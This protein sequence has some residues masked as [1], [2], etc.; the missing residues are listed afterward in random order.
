MREREVEEQQV[1]VE[2][3]LLERVDRRRHLV[4]VAVADHAGLRRA[5]RP[6]R[7]D[8]GE[9]VVLADPAL[10]V[11]ERVG[12]L[13]AVRAASFLELVERFQREHVRQ[14]GDEVAAR[15][16]VED[17]NR[18]DQ[19][20]HVGRIAGRARGIDRRG[21]CADPGECEVRQHPFEARRGH[22]SDHVAFLDSQ[23]EKTEGDLLDAARG[24]LPRDLA[25][26]VLFLGQV[27]G[28]RSVRGHCLL[29]EV[30]DCSAHVRIVR[31]REG[32]V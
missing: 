26:A 21:D 10:R 29:P 4:V 6:G 24:L 3:E 11:G 1:L 28:G 25:P 2:R 32:L 12:M 7:V 30:R 15:L 31:G 14:R 19:A 22:D 16:V 5:G 23:G 20:E 18:L 9:E 27:G 8:E 17:A 13:L